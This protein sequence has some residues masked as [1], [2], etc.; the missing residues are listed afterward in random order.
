MLVHLTTQQ[1]LGIFTY[2]H[3]HY[4]P[5]DYYHFHTT[6]LHETTKLPPGCVRKQ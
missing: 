5:L 1:L 4:M 2:R 3:H 6:K